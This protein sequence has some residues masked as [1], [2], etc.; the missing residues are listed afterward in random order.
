M[1]KAKA[2]DRIILPYMVDMDTLMLKSRQANA[3][4]RMLQHYFENQK[5]AMDTISD[6]IMSDYMWQLSDTVAELSENIELTLDNKIP[7]E[8][9]VSATNH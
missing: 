8:H 1:S 6:E 5:T 9:I 2:D 7:A 4:T 3:L